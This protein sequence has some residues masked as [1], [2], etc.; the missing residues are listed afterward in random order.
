MAEL[1]NSSVR[2][3]NKRGRREFVSYPG[4]GLRQT[5]I[6]PAGFRVPDFARKRLRSRKFGGFDLRPF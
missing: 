6:S 4:R 2:L 1:E 3:K 5:Q